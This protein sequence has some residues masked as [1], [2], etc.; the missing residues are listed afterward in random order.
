MKKIKIKRIDVEVRSQGVYIWLLLSSFPY[1]TYLP[2]CK[3]L[4]MSIFPT[5]ISPSWLWA[6]ASWRLG[7]LIHRGRRDSGLLRT[8]SFELHFII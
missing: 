2:T 3:H 4:L 1:P 6:P 5:D 7:K 8:I